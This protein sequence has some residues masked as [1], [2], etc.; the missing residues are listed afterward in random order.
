MN[1]PKNPNEGD[2]FSLEA[3]LMSI[4]LRLSSLTTGQNSEKAY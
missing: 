1:D 2:D 4:N 3:R